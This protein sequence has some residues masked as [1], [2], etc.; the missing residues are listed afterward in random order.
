VD[1]DNE[2]RRRAT[3]S[4]SHLFAGAIVRLDAGQWEPTNPLGLL[5]RFSDGTEAQAEMIVL[6]AGPSFVAAME[7]GGYT[8]AAGTNIPAKVWGLAGYSVEHGVVALRIGRQ[9]PVHS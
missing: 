9:L 2:R 8:T 1:W 5:I 4:H 7:T 6:A 3:A